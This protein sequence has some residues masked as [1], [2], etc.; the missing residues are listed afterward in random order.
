MIKQ[1]RKY[2]QKELSPLGHQLV[3]N[4]P[5]VSNLQSLFNCIFEVTLPFI[6]NIK[7]IIGGSVYHLTAFQAQ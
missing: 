4:G 5:I 2:F 6:P 3:K 7:T 1:L